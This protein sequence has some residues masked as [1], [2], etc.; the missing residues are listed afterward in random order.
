MKQLV[1]VE[2]HI[3]FPRIPAL[4]KV[5]GKEKPAKYKP[6][7]L[8]YMVGNTFITVLAVDKTGA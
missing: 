7:D 1:W 8:A 5:A 4:W 2:K 3:A 6:E